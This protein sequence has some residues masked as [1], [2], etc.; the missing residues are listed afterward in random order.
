MAIRFFLEYG[1]E[2]VQLPV[3]PSKL[4]VAKGG[5]N[6]TVEVVELGAV[7]ILRGVGLAKISVSSFLP[8]TSNAPYILTSGKFKEPQYYIDFINKVR[9]AKKPLRLIV[10]DTNIN[11]MV[12]IED[13]KTTLN[14][15][16]DDTHYQLS[17]LEY[18][19]YAS[20]VV[21]ITKPITNT[22]P[23]AQSQSNNRNKTDFAVGDRVKVTGKWWY[24]SYGASPYGN[25]P[26]GFV[27]KIG[28][29]I[30]APGR[31]K[32]YHIETLDGRWRGWVGKDQLQ[33]V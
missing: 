13:F 26:N 11:L 5:N 14:A 9:E 16:D 15:Q 7:N 31:A 4:E 23:Q 25:A 29:I 1:D 27:G 8:A 6:K 19:N 18:R 21:T 28:I 10:S 22:N 24:N 12:S 30:T 33:H 3:N 20:K 32:P 2:I 17:L